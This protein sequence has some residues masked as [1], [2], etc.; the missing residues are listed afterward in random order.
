M[1]A[2]T[3]QLPAAAAELQLRELRAALADTQRE[4]TRARAEVRQAVS[5]LA[6]FKVRVRDTAIDYGSAYG[7]CQV[8]DE[9]LAD[10]GLPPATGRY[11][12]DITITGWV[13]PIVNG[14]DQDS[15]AETALNAAGIGQGGL[16]DLLGLPFQVQ[17][18]AAECEA[19]GEVGVGLPPASRRYTVDIKITGRV[20]RTVEVSDQDSAV[21]TA[22]AE[23]GIG[24]G[25]IYDLHGHPFQV[26]SVAAVAAGAG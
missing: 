22:L 17:S 25:G 21:E 7:W 16:Y 11:T 3:D 5:E 19:P 1:N 12:V 14:S 4:L 13:S 23:A 18:V 6:D 20:S 26:E 24:Q 10:L 2:E 9:A 8:L 15:A